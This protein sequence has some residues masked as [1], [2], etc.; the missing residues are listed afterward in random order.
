MRDIVLVRLRG[1][2]N[3]ITPPLGIGYLFKALEGINEV[4]LVFIDEHRDK[5][6]EE[7]LLARIKMTRPIVI[8]FQ[9]FS[10]DYAKFCRRIPKIRKICPEAKII[11]GGPHITG[12]PEQALIDNPDLDFVVKGEGEEAIRLLVLS[13]LKGSLDSRIKDIPNLV[14]RTSNGI[15]RNRSEFVDVNRYGAP[16]WKIIEPHK[17]PPIQQGTF[18]KS[19]RV[20]P[21]LTSRGCPYPCTFCAGHLITGKTIRRRSINSVV[22]EIEFLQAN[23]GFGEI[24]IEDENFTFYKDHILGLSN[25]IQRRN[26]KC[27]FS[28]PNGIRSDRLDEEIVHHLKQIRTYMVTLGIE[29]GSEKTLRAMKKNWDLQALKKKINLLKANGI[30]ILGSFI[31]GFSNETKE[32]IKKTINF[33]IESGVDTAYFGNYIPLPGSEDFNRMIN[34]GEIKLEEINWNAYTSYLGRIPYHPPDI[35]EKELLEAIRWATIRFYCRPKIILNLIKRM[36]R[37]IFLKSLIFRII[38]LF[39][40]YDNQHESKSY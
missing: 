22:D 6:K 34:N 30:S 31:L 19:N 29:S 27:Y 25:E 1:Y 32:D 5:M 3:Y 7:E 40:R 15:V 10:V 20:V 17:Y 14:Y 39:K 11:A 33:A 4:N 9:V 2:T 8:G 18:H 35:S 26:I 36:T 24:I 16:A 12:L 23:Y 21:I 37:P 28:F 13:L 38:N